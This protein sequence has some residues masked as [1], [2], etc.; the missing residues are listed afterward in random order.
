MKKAPLMGCEL[1][2]KFDFSAIF[3]V[4]SSICVYSNIHSRF[5]MNL[6]GVEGTFYCS[7]GGVHYVYSDWNF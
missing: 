1:V 2:Q 6:L 4:I 5:L 3:S 7:K